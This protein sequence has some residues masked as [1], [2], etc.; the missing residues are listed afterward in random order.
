MLSKNDARRMA[1]SLLNCPFCGRKPLA[2]IRGPGEVAINP[3]A[4][5]TTEDCMGGKLPVI[6]L[7]VPS[8]V[9]G[10]NRRAHLEGESKR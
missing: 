9:D 2:S 10:W 4:K 7:D 6:C 3:K 5:C 8:H 1:D